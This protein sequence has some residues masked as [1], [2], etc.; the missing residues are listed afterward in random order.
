MRRLFHAGRLEERLIDDVVSTIVLLPHQQPGTEETTYRSRLRSRRRGGF[1]MAMLSGWKYDGSGMRKHNWGDAVVAN[2]QTYVSAAV[3]ATLRLVF[4]HWLQPVLYFAV[5]YCFWDEVDTVQQVFGAA[6]AVREAGY[7]F[8]TLLCLYANPA[9]LLIN[10]IASVNEWVD[11]GG[12]NAGYVFLLTYT[13]APEKFVFMAALGKGGWAVDGFETVTR[14]NL[15]EI[16]AGGCFARALAIVLL[17]LDLSGVGA[18]VA[19]LASTE[20]LPD[21]LAV[22]YVATALGSVCVLMLACCGVGSGS[23]KAE[24]TTKGAALAAAAQGGFYLQELPL[25]LRA[26]REVVL[27]AVAQNWNAL[28]YASAEL[29]ADREVVL[30][31]VAQN[32]WALEYASAELKADR[33][34]VL[35]AAA[36]SVI[37]ARPYRGQPM[38]LAVSNRH[39]G[40][41]GGRRLAAAASAVA[42]S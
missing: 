12:A 1:T 37:E 10:V 40:R 11:F 21:A 28:E 4:W 27:A 9:F 18:L 41:A 7:V 35:A 31:A 29:Q 15:R 42:P 14:L 8:A 17:A 23:V 20:G 2:D 26:D 5:L 22:G 34:V 13:L 19:G 32:G 30:A 33:E 25:E 6:V 24:Y 36:H 3:A 39:T 38:Q 16:R